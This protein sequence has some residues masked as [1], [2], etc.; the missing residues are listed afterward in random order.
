MF[1]RLFEIKYNNK[2]FAVFVNDKHRYAFMEIKDGELVYPDYE[3]FKHLFEVFNVNN[4]VLTSTM[5]GERL[6]E[7]VDFKGTLLSLIYTVSLM[8]PIALHVDHIVDEKN[9]SIT[10]KYQNEEI[11]KDYVNPESVRALNAYLGFRDITKEEV[12]NAIDNNESF[13][14]R[15]RE[16]TK[17][18]IEAK[19]EINP[20]IDLR[21]IYENVKDIKI[22][23]RTSE[24]IL[25]ELKVHASGCYCSWINTIYLSSDD[26]FLFGHEISHAMHYYSRRVNNREVYV[27][28]GRSSLQECM[29]NKEANMGLGLKQEKLGEDER[30]LNFLLEHADKFDFSVYDEYGLNPLFD[31]LKSK[32]PDADI[33]YIIDFF[34]GAHDAVVNDMNFDIS[35]FDNEYLLD[36]FF[37]MS[38]QSIDKSNAFDE[39]DIL[40]QLIDTNEECAKKYSEKYYKYLIDNSLINIDFN[41][42]TIDYIVYKDN[43]ELYLGTKNNEDNCVNIPLT[44]KKKLMIIKDYCEGIDIFSNEYVSN[45]ITSFD[46]I[47]NNFIKDRSSEEIIKSFELIFEK[48]LKDCSTLEEIQEE[49]FLFIDRTKELD[50]TNSNYRDALMLLHNNNYFFDKYIQICKEKGLINNETFINNIDSIIILDG[51]YYLVKSIDYTYLPRNTFKRYEYEYTIDSEFNDSLT[52]IVYYDENFNEKE[53]IINKTVYSIIDLK[54]KG[55]IKFLMSINNGNNSLSQETIKQVMDEVGIEEISYSKAFTLSNGE[56]IY[57][58]ELDDSVFIEFGKNKEGQITYQISKDDTVI[59]KSCDDFES[60]SSKISYKLFLEVVPGEDDYMDSLLTNENICEGLFFLEPIMKE[61]KVNWIPAE[62]TAIRH[63]QDGTEQEYTSY[64][65]RRDVDFIK[66]V[67]VSLDGQLC[68]AR[69]ITVTSS[70]K[71][72]NLYINYPDGSRDIVIDLAKDNLFD[73]EEEFYFEYLEHYID[74]FVLQPNE[75]GVI[76]LSKEEL[77]RLILEDFTD[78]Y[79]NE[80]KR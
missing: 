65:Y 76:E 29:T 31:E 49:Y 28:A 57:D 37:N 72:S 73:Y 23:Y 13:N 62:K 10:I 27:T 19:M 45:L 34:N 3:D 8:F 68:Y 39:L 70:H 67:L 71:D 74:L 1:K 52:K 58:G 51:K 50:I 41:L 30:A 33:E 24:K 36:Q 44:T 9:K 32:Y 21:L 80:M 66:P 17:A 64:S 22:E 43:N 77:H 6:D 46:I 53:L 69:D 55:K 60:L 42:D 63:N 75:D 59:Y 25:D 2:L 61:V 7:K 79:D 54:N 38:I 15:Q 47:D 40:L 4:G 56:V 14:D 26:D 12:F 16:I 11:E 20:N 5:I 78:I 18:I 48:T 35:M